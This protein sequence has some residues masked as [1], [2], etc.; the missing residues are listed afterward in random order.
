MKITITKSSLVRG[1]QLVVPVASTKST[2]PVL[3]NILVD[4]TDLDNKGLIKLSANDLE[5]GIE[6]YVAATITEK[7]AITIP[8]TK[9]NEIVKELP[10]G[11]IEITENNLQIKVVAGKSKFNIVGL[12]AKDF[13]V[14][15]R[16]D[17]KE[18]KKYKLN[19]DVFV[20]K[21]IKT[22]FSASRDMQKY[23]LTGICLDFKGTDL[24]IATTDG[25]RL[26]Y[27]KYEGITVESVKDNDIQAIVPIKAVTDIVRFV[28]AVQ[29]T[30]E[31]VKE[32][33][34][35]IGDNVLTITV[36][37]I[38]FQTRLIEGTFPNYMQ[39][40]PKQDTKTTDIQLPVG[41]LLQAIKQV[42]LLAG[43]TSPSVILSFSENKLEVYAR[44]DKGE[45]NTELEIVYTGKEPFEMAFNPIFLRE[46]LQSVGTGFVTISVSGVQA[47]TKFTV[48]G[49]DYIY[50]VMPMK[51]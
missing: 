15:V 21:L 12:S 6:C 7:G 25:R 29:A 50:I 14:M 51:R 11:N 4:A 31:T 32:G 5:K 1:L 28:S 20:E 27:A 3:T 8:A 34:L 44:S 46:V 2:L 18:M 10:D 22:M 36:G 13:P 35:I 42:S 37:D 48:E 16:Q 23:V 40:I 26:S 38:V 24:H 9:F 30:T 33:T 49:Q 19:A 43:E 17:E 45:G 41:D 39:V 47:P